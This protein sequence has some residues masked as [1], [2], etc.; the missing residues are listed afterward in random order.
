MRPLVYLKVFGPRE[1]FTTSCKR[2]R[3][4]FLS[5][6]YPYVID[7]LVLGLKGPTVTRATLPEA[8]VRCAL[9]PAHVFY[10]KMRHYL[11]KRS[12]DFSADLPGGTGRVLIHPHAGHLLALAAGDRAG[13]ATNTDAGAV[14]PYVPQEAV[15]G[16]MADRR[17]LLMV[18]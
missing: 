3:E 12:E 14:A 15:M 16:R 11:L 4:G 10:R 2:A 9:G 1:D 13:R 17:V 6:V 5:G 18:D 8:G 7:E